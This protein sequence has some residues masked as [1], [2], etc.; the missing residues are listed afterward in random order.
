VSR[1]TRFVDPFLSKKK[2]TLDDPILA[3]LNRVGTVVSKPRRLEGE[4]QLAYNERR[5]FEGRNEI[6]A[7]ATVMESEIYRGL[8]VPEQADVLSDVISAVRRQLRDQGRVPD[9]WRPITSR[10]VQRA[11]RRRLN[12]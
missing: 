10:V 3:E 12:R 6:E 2:R 9:T 4:D 7:I 8:Q 1:A 5:A 11:R